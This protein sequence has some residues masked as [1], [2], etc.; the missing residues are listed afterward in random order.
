MQY[1]KEVFN[2]FREK[3]LTS[4]IILIMILTSFSMIFVENVSADGDSASVFLIPS[5]THVEVGDNFNITFN[6]NSSV[7]N[8]SWYNV[9]LLTYNESSYMTANVSTND[10]WFKTWTE[11]TDSN[12]FDNQGFVTN[13][14][15]STSADISGNN[16]AFVINFTT[17]ACGVLFINISNEIVREKGAG[18]FSLS[19]NNNTI[20][21]I[22]PPSP[23]SFNAETENATIINVTWTNGAS[24]DGVY[25]EY[26]QDSPPNPWGVGDGTI[27]GDRSGTF[28]EHNGLTP[29]TDYYYKAWGRNQTNGL[30]SVSN[31]TDDS[32]TFGTNITISGIVKDSQNQ[33]L[34]PGTAVMVFKQE[35]FEGE[36]DNGP[37]FTKASGGF[38]VDATNA[39]PGM[40]CVQISRDGYVG[41]INW[42]IDASDGEQIDLGEILL[43]P[44]FDESE[45][46]Y[47]SGKITADGQPIEEGIVMLLD[48]NFSHMPDSGDGAEED[49]AKETQTDQNGNFT[50][51]ISY[52]SNYKIIAFTEGYYANLSSDLSITSPNQVKWYN[53]TLEEAEPDDL[54]I[55]LNFTDLD[56]ATVT[57]S[58]SIIAASRVLRFALDFNPEIG[59]SNSQVDSDEIQMYMYMLSK[60]G[61]N[62]EVGDDLDDSQSKDDEEGMHG[63]DFLST[64]LLLTLDN[65]DFTKYQTGSH[66]GTLDNILN[67]TVDSNQTIYYNATFNVTL[68][69]P[70]KN[71]LSHP[72]NITTVHNETVN[73]NLTIIFGNLYNVIFTSKST[74]VSLSNTSCTMNLKNG[75]NDSIDA[76]AYANVTIEINQSTLSLPIIETPTWNISDRWTFKYSDNNP[77]A[78]NETYKIQGKPLK[79]WDSDRYR[80]GNQNLSYTVYKVEKKNETNNDFYFVTINDIDWLNVTNEKEIDY[81]VNDLDFPLYIGKTWSTTSWWGGQVNATI[82]QTNATKVTENDTF[83]DC[84][85]VNYT[86]E[87]A[88]WAGR[89]WYSPEL[90]FFVNRSQVIP[91]L[92]M[93]TYDLLSY[94]HAPFIESMTVYANDSDQP[95][96]GLINS[97]DINVTINTSK[98]YDGPQDLILEG[99]LYKENYDGPP[100]DISWVFEEDKLR[101]LDVGT[102]STDI[103]LSYSGG[104]IRASGVDG[105]YLGHI[106]LRGKNEWGPGEMLDF[107][108]FEADYNHTDFQKPAASIVSSDDYGNDTDNTKNGKFDYL[109]VNLTINVTE[110][111]N[112]SIH[113]GL[114]K[115]IKH[116]GWDEWYWITGA[117][118]PKKTMNAGEHTI[119]LNF[120]GEEIFERGYNGPY[121]LHLEIVDADTNTIVARNESETKSYLYQNFETPT[122]YFNKS[123][124][125][126]SGMHDFLNDSGFLTINASII[127]EIT[128]GEGDYELCGGLHY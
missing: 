7:E 125:N 28:Y 96:D 72:F 123:T 91:T 101:D 12:I 106:E 104:L 79:P 42:T 116:G 16:T 124:F 108:S 80:V 20:V 65:L 3:F 95:Q 102:G 27:I 74:N 22:H 83:T 30:I 64:P 29:A 121:K 70:V 77:E 61:P 98:F 19:G 82:I 114:D 24:N 90:K 17:N 11:A 112:Y 68:D 60:F 35:F 115:V 40:Y 87:S 46:A 109:T 62:F 94:S 88:G 51:N 97:L 118:I 10:V 73:L 45:T 128:D 23:S 13:I 2:N 99:P 32:S 120:N 58:R 49:I 107:Y 34:L 86:N 57:I 38:C 76:F 50:F 111:G 67:T 18:D 53:M 69:G 122:V 84:V 4:G 59:N 6:I 81:L 8:V 43:E 48:T 39:G 126:E 113:S 66:Q 78:H 25:L 89:Q 103:K 85:L 56:D 1:K 37:Y 36:F 71:A 100:V 63:P 105:P 15:G 41:F 110:T 31:S 47:I 5:E 26:A 33:N 44:L 92:Y 9:S 21:T 119:V 127:V 93:I 117:G 55:I 54:M 52:R 14:N 75:Y